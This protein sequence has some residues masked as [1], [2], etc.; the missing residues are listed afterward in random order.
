[1]P[2]GTKV[3]LGPGHSVLD[4]DSASPK[5]PQSPNFGPMSVVAK[6]SPVSVNDEHLLSVSM[7]I[8]FRYGGRSDPVGVRG[9][10][11]IAVLCGIT[12]LPSH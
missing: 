10:D 1:M 3:G 5:G 6:R 8:G 12:V 7:D 4:E 2:L 11:P 9:P